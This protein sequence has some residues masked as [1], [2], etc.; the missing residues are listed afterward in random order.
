MRFATRTF[1]WSFLPFAILLLGSFWTIHR[2]VES[3]VRDELRSSLRQTHLAIGRVRSRSG[4]QNSRFLKILGENASLKA[5]LQLLLADPKSAAA[6]LTVEDQLREIC[7]LPGFDFLMISDINGAPL[8]AV[9]RIDQQ[10]AAMDVARIRPPQRGF[11]TIGNHSYRVVSTPID[12]GDESIG[13][14]SIGEHFDFSDFGTPAVLMHSG[15]V[16][17]SSIPGIPS[18]EV[19]SALRSCKGEEECE[20]RLR[21][22]TYI[23]LPMESVYL[24]PGYLLRS[25]QNVDRA[26]APVRAILRNVFLL[27]GLGAL[28]AA[29]IVS[30]LA[31]RSIV[32]PMASVVAQLRETEKTGVLPQLDA[33]AASVQEIRDLTESFNRA[34]TSVREARDNLHRAYVEFAGSLASALDA[35]DRY[36][37]GHSRRVSGFACAIAREMGV[38]PEQLEEIR[39]GALLHDIG[40]IGIADGVLQKEGKLTAE[41]LALIRQHPTIGRRILAGVHGFQAYLHAVE[42]HHENWNGTGYPWGLHG[43]EIPLAAR[44]VRVADAYDAMTTDRP[45]R[46]GIAHEQAIRLLEQNAGVQFDPAIVRAA[47]V[48]ARFAGS[49]LSPAKPAMPG[50]YP[51]EN[52]AEAVASDAH[53]FL[54]HLNGYDV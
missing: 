23:S 42:L 48:L 29:L 15:K 34:A 50:F 24:G 47:A 30:M 22:E 53:A 32:K 26:S 52:L 14:L 51:M 44:I 40:K 38:P 39:I 41:E 36:T 45:Y 6:R 5:G 27:A 46:R 1:L 18:E 54:E 19:E 9:I 2:L 4:L 13:I 10:L 49:K 20:V 31:S 28:L 7:D 25:L 11:A 43:E 17:R 16:L 35:R 8:A 3:A 37:A 21:G 33:R 12:Q